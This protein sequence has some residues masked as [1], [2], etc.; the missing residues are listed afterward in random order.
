MPGLDRTPG[1]DR[2]PGLGRNEREAPCS[3]PRGIFAESCEA[4]GIISPCGNPQGFL[5]KKDDC[6]ERFCSLRKYRIQASRASQ[7]APKTMAPP[8]MNRAK[9]EVGSLANCKAV[10]VIISST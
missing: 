6:K 7:S 5:A 1:W 2:N 10:R 4:R 8:K 9:K 3:E